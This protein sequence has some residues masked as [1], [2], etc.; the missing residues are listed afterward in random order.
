MASNAPKAPTLHDS[1]RR[2]IARR[3]AHRARDQYLYAPPSESD[4]QISSSRH[5]S[6]REFYNN[7]D[8]PRSVE[9][10]VQLTSRED[11]GPIESLHDL[12]AS[13]EASERVS[14]G[15]D[16]EFYYLPAKIGFD[17]AKNDPSKIWVTKREPRREIAAPLRGGGS[18]VTMKEIGLNLELR[19]R[20]RESLELLQIA[21]VHRDH[22]DCR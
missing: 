10:V 1:I 2:E 3:H 7:R 4:G 16:C 11:S 9:A 18:D 19:K 14:P 6:D 17:I 8:V 21:I 20:L 12:N 15:S 5:E 22:G 13:D